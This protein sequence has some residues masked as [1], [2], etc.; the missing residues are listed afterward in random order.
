MQR[1][2]KLLA[3]MALPIRRNPV[4]SCAWRAKGGQHADRRFSP[5]QKL[6]WQKE[7]RTLE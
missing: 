5:K 4:A 3:K 6:R 2:C 7:M 1:K